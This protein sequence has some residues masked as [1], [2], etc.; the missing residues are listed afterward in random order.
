MSLLLSDEIRTEYDDD[1]QSYFVVWRPLVAI[2]MGK[3]EQAVLDDLRAAAHF[4]IETM[5]RSKSRAI[6]LGIFAKGGKHGEQ[7]RA[8]GR[9]N[10]RDR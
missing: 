4:G 7:S 9:R 1:S 6:G 5:V 10:L 2:G 8:N 3:T